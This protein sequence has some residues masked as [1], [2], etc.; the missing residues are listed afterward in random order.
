MVVSKPSGPSGEVPE[1]VPSAARLAVE[2]LGSPSLHPQNITMEELCD[3]LASVDAAQSR[4]TQGK[5]I[6]SSSTLK[7][8]WAFFR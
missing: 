6:L 4:A 2:V 5:Y 7:C 8:H 3:E 1:S